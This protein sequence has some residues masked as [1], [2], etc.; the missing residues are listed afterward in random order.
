MTPPTDFADAHGRHWG[1]AEL[2]YAHECLANADQLYGFSAECG[3]KALMEV[4]GM[5]LDPSGRPPGQY[6]KGI[7][8]LARH[9]AGPFRGVCAARLSRRH[10]PCI[11]SYIHSTGC[12]PHSSRDGISS[13]RTGGSDRC[14]VALMAHSDTAPAQAAD[15]AMYSYACARASA[16]ATA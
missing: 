14:P 2:L 5:R 10:T 16:S 12:Y 11:G 9:D 6:A 3:L 15:R 4:L 8:Y 13:A 1:D 7:T